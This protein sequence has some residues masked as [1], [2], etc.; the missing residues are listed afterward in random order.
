[1]I[2]VSGMG[3]LYTVPSSAA[4]AVWVVGAEGR[5]RWEDGA[6]L[7]PKPRRDLGRVMY[8]ALLGVP[9]P[10]GIKGNGTRRSPDG[11][12]RSGGM[13]PQTPLHH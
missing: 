11:Q 1:M 4:S 3:R 8:K 10:R 9:M 6:A 12:R 13:R 7:S 5:K 2:M